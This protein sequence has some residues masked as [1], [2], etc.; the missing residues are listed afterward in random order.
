MEDQLDKALTHLDAVKAALEQAKQAVRVA[1]AAAPEVSRRETAWSKASGLCRRA[2]AFTK[3]A[4]SEQLVENAKARS[5]F[6]ARLDLCEKS[7]L[8]YAMS[9]I[10]SDFP[11]FEA[12]QKQKQAIL[13]S[14]DKI[15]K[16]EELVAGILERAE[17][18]DLAPEVASPSPAKKKRRLWFWGS[19]RG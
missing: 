16:E 18:L 15:K 3:H 10:D 7:A 11:P 8:E 17:K 9:G 5:L 6:E 14:L 1:G 13:S 2:V 19:G 4:Q 12:A